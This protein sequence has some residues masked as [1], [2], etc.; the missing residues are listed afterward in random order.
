M[1]KSQNR[2]KIYMILY[3]KNILNSFNVKYSR[4]E[5]LLVLILTAFPTFFVD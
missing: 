2:I 5:V 1:M 4:L 3:N